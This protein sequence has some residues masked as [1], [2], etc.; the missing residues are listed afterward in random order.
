MIKR[1]GTCSL[2]IPL[3]VFKVVNHDELKP[4]LLSQI[5]ELGTYSYINEGQRISHTDWHLRGDRDFGYKKIFL[6][7]ALAH[8]ALLS[9]EI[10]RNKYTG[11]IDECW[12]QQ[13][14]EGDYHGLHTHNGSLASVYYLELGDKAPHTTLSIN[15]KEVT[16]PVAEGHIISFP[17]YIEYESKPN[18]TNRKTVIAYN[19]WFKEVL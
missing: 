5:E 15:G 6:P 12:F 11:F 8:M 10:H 4:K 17:S 9:K 16:I 2:E 19:S 3:F 1:I 13:Y 18:G 7:I 14:N